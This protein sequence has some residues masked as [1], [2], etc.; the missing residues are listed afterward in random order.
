MDLYNYTAYSLVSM[1]ENKNADEMNAILANIEKL[2]E[3]KNVNAAK[4]YLKE[5]WNVDRSV[6]SLMIATD[7][8]LTTQ[9]TNDIFCINFVYKNQNISYYY[10]K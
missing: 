2:A 10:K 4:S 5:K 3:Q 9:E 7:C 8:K 1:A 6:K